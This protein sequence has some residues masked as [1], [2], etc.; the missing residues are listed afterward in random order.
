V[1]PPARRVHPDDHAAIFCTVGSTSAKVRH[2]VFCI[3]QC[4]R[5]WSNSGM[6]YVCTTSCGA[7]SI[8]GKRAGLGNSSSARW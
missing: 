6:S 3:G 8:D 2:E 7:H 4:S 5:G 1:A